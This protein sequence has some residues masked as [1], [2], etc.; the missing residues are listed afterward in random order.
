MIYDPLHR[1]KDAPVLG[2][3]HGEPGPFGRWQPDPED[4]ESASPP[5]RATVP[6]P[7]QERP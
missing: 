4:D 3:A 7:R 2:A 6:A 5:C 1:L